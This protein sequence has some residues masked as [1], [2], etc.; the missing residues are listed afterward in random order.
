MAT[1][2]IAKQ[3]LLREN[4]FT[5]RC[6]RRGSSLDFKELASRGAKK[7]YSTPKVA[8][9]A[10]QALGPAVA[11]SQARRARVHTTFCSRVAGATD[12]CKLDNRL[13]WAFKNRDMRD[14]SG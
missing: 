3:V 11:A 7:F 12:D 14:L 13:S 1:S 2:A 5:S 4:L 9:S 8:A 10:V 6:Y